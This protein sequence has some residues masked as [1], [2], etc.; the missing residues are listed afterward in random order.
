MKKDI[1]WEDVAIIIAIYE[2]GI[3]AGKFSRYGD[4]SLL[5]KYSKNILKQFYKLKEI[6]E[7]HIS[8]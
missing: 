5:Q 7:K 4:S 1:T 8:Q 2:D 6:N 3:E